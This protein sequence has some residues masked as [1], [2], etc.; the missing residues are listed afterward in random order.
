MVE[1][2]AFITPP[3]ADQLPL[4]DQVPDPMFTVPLDMM[5]PLAANVMLNVLASKVP[6]PLKV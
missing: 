4:P 6:V 3:V 2:C 1:V 5:I